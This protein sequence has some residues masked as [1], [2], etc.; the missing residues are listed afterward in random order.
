MSI[1]RYKQKLLADG[2]VLRMGGSGGGGTTVNQSNTNIPEYARPYVEEMLGR[3]GALTDTNQNPFPT[4][5]GQRLADFN[6]LQ[7]QAFGNVANMTTAGQLGTG[8][9]LATQA[10]QGSLGLAG[11]MAGAG[12]NYANM[13]TDPNAVKSYMNPYIEGALQPQLN[14][15]AQEAGM[16]GAG[17]Q[18]AATQ[19]GAFGGSRSALANSLAQQ[20]GLMAQQAAL[21][22]G[23]DQAFKAAQQAQ[24]FGASLGLQGQQGALSAYGQAN[25]A[26]NTLGQLG[27]EQFNQQRFINQDQQTTGAVQQAQAQQDYDQKYQDWVN[28][29][30]YP[31]EQLGF[32]SDMLRGL[33]LSQGTNSWWSPGPSTASQLGGLGLAGLG[34]YG[35]SGGFNKAKGGVIKAADGG[36]MA[37]KRFQDGGMPQE[38][39]QMTSEQIIKQLNEM[40]KDPNLDPIEAAKIKQ[41]IA[42]YTRMMQNPETGKI[43]APAEGGI[44]SIPTGNM[45]PEQ[46]AGGG[47]VA[48]AK[49][50]SSEDSYKNWLENQVRASTEKQLGENAFSKSD[51]EKAKLESAIAARQESAPW[52]ALTMAGLGTAAGQ[53][54]HALSNLGAG[55]LEGYKSYAKTKGSLASD[56]EKLLDAQLYADRYEDARKSA[57]TGQMNTTL[58]HLYAKDAARAA[59]NA[60]S[61]D[62]NLFK[63]I[64]L[65]ER[66][67][68]LKDYI[69]KRK[70]LTEGTPEY[71][72]N[73]KRIAERQND[74]YDFLGIKNAPAKTSRVPDYVK[75]EETGFW[76]SIFGSKKP[77]ASQNKVVP[78]SQ[79]PTKG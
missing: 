10:G 77:A 64:A 33:P 68:M 73:E 41:K 35:M 52:E 45:V 60:G 3:T 5:G 30:K 29:K 57:L 44:N 34:I 23:Y 66:D 46:M 74:I 48:F 50:G 18:G 21:G 4:Y 54:P 28:E 2:G 19:A 9:N 25:S 75:P 24:Q 72:V 8:T 17:Q 69:G 61:E 1:L 51:A 32:M 27:Q 39:P 47:I 40:L 78:F 63:A 67:P 70:T 20:N 22:Q 7:K 42:V 43:M 16:K 6:S 38:A 13:A 55:A 79:L 49:G 58:G 36:L 14:Q 15:L 71:E 12:Q 11:Q 26:A 62:K 76:D 53:S 56:R 37:A 59:A 31:Y 65:M